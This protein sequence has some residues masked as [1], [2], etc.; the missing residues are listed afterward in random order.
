MLYSMSTYGT[1]GVERALQIL[2]ASPGVRQ[3]RDWRLNFVPFTG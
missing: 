2:K 3:V 1:A